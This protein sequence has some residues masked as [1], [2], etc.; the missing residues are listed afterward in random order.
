VTKP[1]RHVSR[2]D[3][4]Q[5]ERTASPRRAEPTQPQPS[6]DSARSTHEDNDAEPQPDRDARSGQRACTEEDEGVVVA[7]VCMRRHTR[8]HEDR[9]SAVRGQSESPGAN[10][11]PTCG[12]APA[13]PLDDAWTTAQVEREAGGGCVDQNGLFAWIPDP[14]DGGPAA[15]EHDSRWR[16]SQAQRL[17]RAARGGGRD[18]RHRERQADERPNHRPMTVNVTVAV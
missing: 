15:S 12:R 8:G 10:R 1:L 2:V 9:D 13:V 4:D 16:R 7:G 6:D 17:P 11:Q 3:H 14:H 5:L 18:K